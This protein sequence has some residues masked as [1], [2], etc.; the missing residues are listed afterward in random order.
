[1]ELVLYQLPKI[2]QAME[3]DDTIYVV[4]GEKDADRLNTLGL[5]A[6]TCPM[7]AKKWR[8]SY[9]ESL[10]DARVVI[11]PDADQAGRDHAAQVAQSLHGRAASVKVLQLP[12]LPDKGDVSDW[13]GSGGTDTELVRMAQEVP[14]WTPA[15]ARP[16]LGTF[17]AAAHSHRRRRTGPHGLVLGLRPPRVSCIYP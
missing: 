9:S 14:E 2:L 15:Q 6:T 10:H 8:D 13:L 3:S 4:E 7:G 16:L 5:T 12:G 1:M 11:L 17:T